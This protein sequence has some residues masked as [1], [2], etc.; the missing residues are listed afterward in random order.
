MNNFNLYNSR[1][2]KNNIFKKIVKY[3]EMSNLT[4][5]STKIL[6]NNQTAIYLCKSSIYQNIQI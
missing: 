4:I 6:W 3:V 5:N 1:I 2:K